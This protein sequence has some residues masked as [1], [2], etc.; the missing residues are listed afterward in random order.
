MKTR[1]LLTGLL[2]VVAACNRSVSQSNEAVKAGIVE[3]LNKGSGLDLSLMDVQVTNV[4]FE[5][6]TA[7]ASVNFRPKSAPDQGMQMNYTLESKD[8]KWVVVGKA[9]SQAGHGADTTPA[10][11]GGALPPGHP[12]VSPSEKS[13]Q[14]K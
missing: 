2:L 10:P 5:G 13:G 11:G 4:T 3:H 9:G 14:P 12:P 8:G 7:K 1:A 6:T